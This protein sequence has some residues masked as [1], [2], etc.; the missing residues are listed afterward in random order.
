MAKRNSSHFEAKFR[1]SA[2]Y[3]PPVNSYDNPLEARGFVAVK[4]TEDG[5]LPAD[6]LRQYGEWV[7]F[8]DYPTNHS[9]RELVN[10]VLTE[11]VTDRVVAYVAR[12]ALDD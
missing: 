5:P 4:V 12:E 8:T 11:I 6:E 1:I 7:E 2:V 9:V 3:R 10:R